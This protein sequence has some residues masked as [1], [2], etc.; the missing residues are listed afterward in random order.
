MYVK[1]RVFSSDGMSFIYWFQEK[2]NQVYGSTLATFAPWE[3]RLLPMTRWNMSYRNKTHHVFSFQNK[4]KGID[5]LKGKYDRNMWYHFLIC[6]AFSINF[7]WGQFSIINISSSLMI[8]ILWL[9]SSV[10][11]MK[12]IIPEMWTLFQINIH[13]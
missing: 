9:L 1:N 8:M 13:N 5:K 3:L 4:R 2:L 11:Y 12:I 6:L 10:K 7:R